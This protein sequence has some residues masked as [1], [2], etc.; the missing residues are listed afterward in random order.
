MNPFFK[1]NLLGMDALTVTSLFVALWHSIAKS[2][3]YGL[4]HWWPLTQAG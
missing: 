2:M 3:L 1:A 4:L